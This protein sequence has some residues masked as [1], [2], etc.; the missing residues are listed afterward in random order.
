METWGGGEEAQSDTEDSL[1]KEGGGRG[2]KSQR[3]WFL[4]KTNLLGEVPILA[5]SLSFHEKQWCHES[6]AASEQKK[7][8]KFSCSSSVVSKQANKYCALCVCLDF[9][10][11]STIS[12]YNFHT[13]VYTLFKLLCIVFTHCYAFENGWTDRHIS[14]TLQVY[15]VQPKRKKRLKKKCPCASSSDFTNHSEQDLVGNAVN[16][17]I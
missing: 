11:S 13:L 2:G 4:Q 1:G 6:A 12:I 9:V 16:S 14:L 17:L 5:V 3:V 10:V 8:S 15:W 7:G